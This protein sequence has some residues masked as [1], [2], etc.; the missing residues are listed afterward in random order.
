MS[1]IELSIVTPERRL[2]PGP[3][4]GKL[5]VDE[6]VAPGGRGSFGVR[7]GHTPF[8]TKVEPGELWY[9]QGGATV[10]FAIGAGFIEV[11]RD[12]V[13]VLAEEALPAAQIDVEQARQALNEAESKMKGADTREVAY[14]NAQARAQ[15][16]RARLTVAGVKV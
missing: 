12:R 9:R 2:A 5:L 1:Q 11:E 13:S 10:K 8:L 6:V 15:W 14:A 3:E 16:A 4:E 7:P